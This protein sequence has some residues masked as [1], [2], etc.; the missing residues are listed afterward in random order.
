[1]VQGIIWADY[2]SWCTLYMDYI[3]MYSQWRIFYRCILMLQYALIVKDPAMINVNVFGILANTVYMAVYYYFSPQM[4]WIFIY[5]MC[6]MLLPD[7]LIYL[8]PSCLFIFNHINSTGVVF[9]FCKFYF[10][11]WIKNMYTKIILSSC[12]LISF[13]FIEFYMAFINI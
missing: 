10:V 4:V 12:T 9:E 6:I 11:V 13:K 2:V 3:I 8:F 5:I 1:M 7:T